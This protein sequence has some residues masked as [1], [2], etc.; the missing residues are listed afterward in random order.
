MKSRQTWWN[1]SWLLGGL[2]MVITF[3][4]YLPALR[5]GFIWDDD[6]WTTG[7]AGLLR[8]LPGLQTMWLHSTSLQQYYPL[9]GTSFWL[10]YHLWGFRALPCHA[11]NVLLH[12]MAALLGLG[13]GYL[14]L[15]RLLAWLHPDR[16]PLPH[17]F[18]FHW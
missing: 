12:A 10:D 13:I 16:F 14:V 8:D 5:G 9:T 6:S 7:I 17:W 3:L 11:E 18:P 4:A 15:V 2:L 1:R